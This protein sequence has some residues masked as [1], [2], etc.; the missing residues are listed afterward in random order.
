M[1]LQVGFRVESFPPRPQTSGSKLVAA[2]FG[3]GT[4]L[5]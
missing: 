2:A 3:S 5:G 1:N 4:P